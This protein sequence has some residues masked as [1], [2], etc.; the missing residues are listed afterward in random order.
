MA[1]SAAD[2]ALVH[3][4]SSTANKTELKLV[5]HIFMIVVVYKFLIIKVV[6]AHVLLLFTNVYSKFWE[7][8]T[9]QGCYHF[10]IR[11][12]KKHSSSIMK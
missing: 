10:Y 1:F 2:K 4:P 11:L 6:V 8:A 7:K 5:R 9:D 12:K 3:F